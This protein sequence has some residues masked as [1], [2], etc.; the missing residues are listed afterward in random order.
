M[1]DELEH[2]RGSL[3]QLASETR[4]RQSCA[5][6][7][8]EDLAAYAT[9]ELRAAAAEAVLEHLTVC[10]PCARL[11]LG[12]PAFLAKAALAPELEATADPET[13]DAWRELQDR[14]RAGPAAPAAAVSGPDEGSGERPRARP[15]R[16]AILA[17]AACL[18]ACLIGFPAW[19]VT[20]E[21]SRV[22]PPIVT[23]NPPERMLG[24]TPPAATPAAALRL[25]AEAS[26]LVLYLPAPQAYPRLR[27]E[28]ESGDGKTRSPAAAAPIS[29]QAV[30]VLLTREQLPPGDYRLRVLG[31]DSHR[32]QPLGDY[33]LR[34]VGGRID[35]PRLAH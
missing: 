3:A 19:I 29:P 11:L 34:I 13:D 10:R 17:L 23:V 2:L 1:T 7:R 5:H 18:A 32:R 22:P 12:L 16:Q 28:I 24:A 30:L 31:V 26:A 14:L 25:D 27:V 20:Q 35:A 21:R 8:P 9:G 15:R 4:R 6:P 33:P